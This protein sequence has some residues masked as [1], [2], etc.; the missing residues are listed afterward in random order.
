MAA[1][2][3]SG[4][5][6]FASPPPSGS[7]ARSCEWASWVMSG[8]SRASRCS[9]WRCPCSGFRSSVSPDGRSSCSR[10]SR[11]RRHRIWPSRSS[12][13]PSPMISVHARFPRWSCATVSRRTSRTIV[14]VPTFL[15]TRAAIDEQIERLE[16][17][18]LASQDGDLH[19]A[20]L[21][22]WTDSSTEAAPG[23]EELLGAA[24]DGIARLNR[25]YGGASGGPRFFLL[26]RRRIW[27]EGQRALDRLGAQ[28][29]EAARAEPL[30]ARGDRH[31]L[32]RHRRRPR[33]SRRPAS[34]T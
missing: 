11:W 26:H 9:S 30:A 3:S 28:A 20:L 6:G 7:F 21:S 24:A 33:P 31:E 34:A 29:R 23:D 17:H 16:I 18:H 4:T 15:T 8:R 12:T 19:F 22:D 2:T 25:R 1:G 27:N 32:C 5:S 13:A 14:V 10:C